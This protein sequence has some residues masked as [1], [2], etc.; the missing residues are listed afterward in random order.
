[1]KSRI[2]SESGADASGSS[3]D[4]G[5]LGFGGLIVLASDCG[6]PGCPVSVT[7]NDDPRNDQFAVEVCVERKRSEGDNSGTGYLEFVD[8]FNVPENCVSRC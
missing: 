6:E 4:F 5:E 1:M 8:D 3:K 7:A 2:S